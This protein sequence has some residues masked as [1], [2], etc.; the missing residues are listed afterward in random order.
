MVNH[1][2]AERGTNPGPTMS[3]L[4]PNLQIDHLALGTLNRLRLRPGLPSRFDP[5][6]PEPGRIAFDDQREVLE[7]EARFIAQERSCVQSMVASAPS[8]PGLFIDWFE[9][10]REVGPGQNDPL[11]EYLAEEATFEELRWFIRQEVAGEAGFEDLVALTQ[12]KMPQR[13]KLELALNYWDEMGRGKPAAMHGPLLDRLARVLGVEATPPEEIVWEALAVANLMVAMAFDRRYAFHSIGA[14]GVI[15][16]TAPT[17][18]VRVVRAFDRLG[19]D[20]EASFYFRLHASIDIRHWAGW[21]K[22]VLTSVLADHPEVTWCLA[23]GALMRLRAGARTFDRYR[24]ELGL[25]SRQ[26]GI[27]PSRS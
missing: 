21:R 26:L 7:T 13:A 8:D 17:R 14:L 2:L 1:D 10:L 27:E 12:L 5:A 20:S 4:R 6:A 16:L 25:G 18:A 19:V 11:F 22:N 15:E 23:E 3:R 9:S 24:A